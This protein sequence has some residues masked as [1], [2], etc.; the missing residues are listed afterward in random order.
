MLKSIHSQNTAIYYAISYLVNVVDLDEGKMEGFEKALVSKRED[1]LKRFGWLDLE[2]KDKSLG[3]VKQSF[4]TVHDF[5]K[6]LYFHERERLK[7]PNVQ[8]GIRALMILASESV[9]NLDK[10]SHY[11]NMG[12]QSISQLKEYQELLEFYQKKLVKRLQKVKEQEELWRVEWGETADEEE[13]QQALEDLSCVSLDSDYELFYLKKEDGSRFFT[14][15][16]LRHIKLIRDF[17]HITLEDSYDDPNRY[18]S[19]IRD[20]NCCKAASDFKEK[21]FPSME[22]FF[23]KHPE[24]NL[25]EF[26]GYISKCLYALFLTSSSHNDESK[27]AN[28]SCFEYFND[29]WNFLEEALDSPDYLEML[30]KN[31]T[32]PSEHIETI[33]NF[34]H[35][36]CFHLFMKIDIK[37]AIIGLIHQLLKKDTEDE[38]EEY[39]HTNSKHLWNS[40]LEERNYIDNVL[41]SYPN[42]PLY[43]TIDNLYIRDGYKKFEPLLQQN[44]SSLLYKIHNKNIKTSVIRLPSPTHQEYIHEAKVSNVFTGFIEGV[45]QSSKDAK[46]LLF[47][48]QDKTSW[49]EYARVEVLEKLPEKNKFKDCLEVCT[50]PCSSEFYEQKEEYEKL[51]D[52]QDFKKVF[53]SQI[54]G[55]DECGFHYSHLIPKKKACDFSKACIES[56]H[57]FFFGSKEC[58]SKKNRENFID[59]FYFFF[60]LKII[61]EVKPTFMSF[62]CKDSIDLGSC[63]TTGFYA[64]SKLMGLDPEWSQEEENFL[65]YLLFAP[66]LLVRQRI[67]QKGPSERMLSALSTL[68]AE[69]DIQRD[70]VVSSFEKLFDYKIFQNL[71]TEEIKD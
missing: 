27:G 64:F 71:C 31:K 13:I 43:N 63:L 2:N 18:L 68:H 34:I 42:N 15:N 21:L 29:A 48:L 26:Y 52:A 53:L 17:Y 46:F 5:L 39:I 50:L 58:L 25:S 32:S 10:L 51:N 60:S 19:Y 3:N 44:H 1:F 69:L 20:K 65:T 67:T 4:K 61:D 6:N 7:D 62:T 45:K 66:A 54:E 36:M 57:E 38:T 56:I 49:R 55:E 40:I 41:K 35:S 47:N 37:D 11:L 16:L 12:N 24:F 9:H 70:K 22:K 30:E 8:K 23:K 33:T 14:H 28:K 59:I